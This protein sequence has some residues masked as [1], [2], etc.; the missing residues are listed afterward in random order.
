MKSFITAVAISWLALGG[1]AQAIDPPKLS[2]AAPIAN[3]FIV[4]YQK[5][6]SAADRQKHEDLIHVAAARNNKYRG[7]M[8]KF[9]I[10]SFQGY[11]IEIDPKA[12]AELQNTKLVSFFSP[13]TYPATHPVQ[14]KQ[15][16]LDARITIASPISLRDD[17][18]FPSNVRHVSNSTW[19]QSRLSHRAPN[20]R[21]GFLYNVGGSTAYVIDTGIR[22][23]HSE[24]LGPDNTTSRAIW[25]ANFINGSADTDENGHGTHVAGTIGGRTKG[26]A[27][28][29]ELVAVKVFDANGSGPWSGVLAGLDFVVRH[30]TEN[31]RIGRA[32]V[33]MS[34]GGPR[35]QVVDD[36]VAA[37]VDA[38]VAVVVAAGNAGQ[39]T[40]TTSPAGCPVAITVAAIDDSDTRPRWS[41]YGAEV[42]LFAP[43]ADVE[44]ATI[45]DDHAYARE[46][47]TSMA[48]PHVAGLVAY[49]MS[50]YGAHTPRQ[51]MDRLSQWATRDMVKDAMGSPNLIAFNGNDIFGGP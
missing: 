11:H 29:T 43:G 40:N 15:V 23:S 17:T 7:I 32:V 45:R 33:N 20:Y 14:I 46:S 9:N 50:L 35:W 13:S 31:K 19:G 6:I 39:P 51:M 34:L 21:S 10:G 37:A 44:S 24:F 16:Q 47:G 27:P 8:K 49:F 4:Q 41:N 36:A 12:V 48:A 3:N 1:H 5:D 22:T 30:A 28:F 38:G 18:T 26:I 42:D 2:G 25:G